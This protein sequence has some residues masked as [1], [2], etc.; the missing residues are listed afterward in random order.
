LDGLVERAKLTTAHEMLASINEAKSILSLERR[1]GKQ[2]ETTIEEGLVHIPPSGALL[3][4]GDIHGDL[5]SLVR[6]LKTGNTVDKIERREKKLL[7]LGDYGDRGKQSPEV[8]AVILRLKIAYPESVILL[9]GNHEGPKDIPFIPNDLPSQLQERFHDQGRI[10]IAI[11]ELFEHFHHAAILD[12]KYLFIHGG[13]PSLSKSAEDVAKANLSHPSTTHLE[14]MLWNDPRE[15]MKGT[16][17]SSRGAGKFFGEDVTRR[18]LGLMNAKTLIRSHEP[19]PEGFSF[20]HSG[21][22]LT[23]F[24]RKGLPYGNVNAACLNMDVS[25]PPLF[26]YELARLAV[27]F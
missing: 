10:C 27:T 18:V 8:Y 21:M 22:V 12:G 19:C 13:V 25:G 3:V 9:R 14:E 4:V 24:S 17:P 15:H 16:T 26:S 20:S 1:Q 23:V 2:G 5:E 6:V 7:F 11:R